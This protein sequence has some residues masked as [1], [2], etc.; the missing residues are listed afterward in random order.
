MKKRVRDIY[1]YSFLDRFF[2]PASFH[3]C[4]NCPRGVHHLGCIVLRVLS[5]DTGLQEIRRHD[6]G[7]TKKLSPQPP[8]PLCLDTKNWHA[9]LTWGLSISP[10]VTRPS[11]PNHVP[12]VKQTPHDP[13]LQIL[14]DD[15]QKQTNSHQDAEFSWWNWR[16]F[17]WLG[18]SNEKDEVKKHL[19]SSDLCF[20][21][22]FWNA[23]KAWT[24]ALVHST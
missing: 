4:Q 3:Q 7:L 22:C 20:G 1:L 12:Y 17:W 10:A 19:I 24:Q 16:P 14:I 15:D 2:I 13:I 8:S 11:T 18:Y 23:V 21:K 9:F 5:S 6:K